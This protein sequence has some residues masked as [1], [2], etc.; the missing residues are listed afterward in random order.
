MRAERITGVLLVLTAAATVLGNIGDPYVESHDDRTKFV[1]QV[2][3]AADRIPLIYVFQAA[4][5]VRVF[6]AVGA[7]V[8]LYLLLRQRA[9]GV[10]L[11]GLLMR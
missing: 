3:D 2:T 1:E 11:A 6:M 5:V 9:R 10:G 7:G 8:G 4:D